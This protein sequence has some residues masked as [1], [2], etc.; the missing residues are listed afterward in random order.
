L[1]DFAQGINW[2]QAKSCKQRACVFFGVISCGLL[3]DYKWSQWRP[4]ICKKVDRISKFGPS[5]PQKR[6]ID[7]TN[8]GLKSAK[9]WTPTIKS[10]LGPGIHR[11]VELSSQGMGGW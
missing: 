3:T 2:D 10:F 5:N 4:Q 6:Y 8:L 9:S 7:L 1:L 11:V